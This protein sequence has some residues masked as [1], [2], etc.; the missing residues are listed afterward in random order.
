MKAKEYLNGVRRR[1]LFCRT[2]AEKLDELEH[3]A[4]GLKA[5]TYDKD[6]VQTS[7]ENRMEDLMVQISRIEERYNKAITEYHRYVLEAT[8]RV[9][10]MPNDAHVE[11]LRLRYLTDDNG[12][13]MSF[14]R[15]ACLMNKSFDWVRHLHGAA[16]A[17][18]ERLYLKGGRNV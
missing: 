14:E 7:P 16:L 17:E 18:F 8:E 15:I 11:I 3:Q 5:I 13:R 6:R 12:R 9:L 2:L 4:T 10:R 1:Q